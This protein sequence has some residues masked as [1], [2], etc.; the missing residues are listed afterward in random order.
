MV[1]H[2]LPVKIRKNEWN[3]YCQIQFYKIIAKKV[4][5]F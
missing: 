5:F 4:P 3:A 2:L 1:V